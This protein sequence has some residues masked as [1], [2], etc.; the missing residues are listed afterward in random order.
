MELANLL[1]EFDK[2]LGLNIDKKQEIK[3]DIPEEILKLLEKRKK[4]REEKNWAMSD[5]IR[6]IIQEKG[7][8][9]K[10]SKSEQT[11]ERRK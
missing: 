3:E 6:D 5:E 2:I 1:L 9:I 7:Y 8:I 11:I 4:A 10:D